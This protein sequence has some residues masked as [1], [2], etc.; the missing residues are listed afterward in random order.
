MASV[1][2]RHVAM[3]LGG[4][5]IIDDLTLE[6]AEGEFLVLLGPS[7]CG[8]S[9][10]LH[11]IA[12]LLQ[13]SGG[14]IEIDRADMTEVDP[15]ERN[16]GMVFQSY[17]LYPTM[18]VER[19][20]SFGLRMRGMRRNEIEER[21]L[22]VARQL[23]LEGL[24]QRKPAAL[25]GG[26]R[27]R[28]AIGRALVRDARVYLLDE[29]LSNLDAGLRATLRRELKLLHQ[30][31]RATMIYVTHDQIEAL[32]LATRVAVMQRGHIQQ[33]GTPAEVYGRPANRFVAGFLG[34][35]GMNFIEGVIELERDGPRFAA[36]GIAVGLAGYRFRGT[37]PAPGDTV[38]LGVRP[39]HVHLDN[40]GG[41]SG[42]VTVVEPMGN[43]RLVWLD[44]LGTTLAALIEGARIV[45]TGET[46]RWRVDP[47]HV[48][49]FDARNGERL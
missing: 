12:G 28:V 2:L 25:S 23:Q 46:V 6:V 11:G 24:L 15:A 45:R 33:V 48:S 8:K 22:R 26:Q 31:L 43:Q 5:R 14:R 16:I 40:G 32:T 42:Q 18:S 3:S 30:R 1:S 9:T 44:A 19:N 17:A 27:Q 13:L 29:P 35:P 37:A 49:V 36:R 20:L 21:V 39:E 34:S 7:G 47:E 10:L 4:L 38:V 41:A